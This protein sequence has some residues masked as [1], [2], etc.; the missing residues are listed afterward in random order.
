MDEQSWAGDRSLGKT[1][2]LL[3]E[4]CGRKVAAPGADAVRKGV[5]KAATP[6]KG[7]KEEEEEED[8]DK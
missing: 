8:D 3:Q 7:G 1:R 5:D 6:E 4:R 2:L